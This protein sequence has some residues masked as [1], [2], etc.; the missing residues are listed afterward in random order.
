MKLAELLEFLAVTSST[1]Q[2]QLMID[3]PITICTAQLPAR[4]ALTLSLWLN[5]WT[6]QDCLNMQLIIDAQ[7]EAEV[8]LTPICS[9]DWAAG[10]SWCCWWDSWSWW[11]W[12][13]WSWPAVAEACSKLQ[14]PASATLWIAGKQ[15]S[16]A[17]QARNKIRNSKYV[18][19]QRQYVHS[20]TL[21]KPEKC[22]RRL[23][24]KSMYLVCTSTYWYT[25]LYNWKSMYF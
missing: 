7:R 14:E 11:W 1:F 21:K 20:W 6:W 17:R 16:W 23:S 2:S 22:S 12:V 3:V 18:L 9:P 24:Q 13:W 4:S 25:L 5:L 8:L 10:L 19:R 15:T